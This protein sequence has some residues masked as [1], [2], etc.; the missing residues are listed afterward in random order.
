MKKLK[1]IQ[2]KLG[3]SQRGLAEIL[4]VTQAA[5]SNHISGNRIMNVNSAV[6]LVKH[7]RKR[8]IAVTLDALY[9]ELLDD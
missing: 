5:I 7:C 6:K 1:L 9:K 8:K 2:K 3:V 4:D